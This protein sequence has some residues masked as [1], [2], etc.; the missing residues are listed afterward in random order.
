MGEWT[1]VESMLRGGASSEAAV[2]F[3]INYRTHF[4][5]N[6]EFFAKKA[7]QTAAKNEEALGAVLRRTFYSKKLVFVF[8]QK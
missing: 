8:L 3:L 4:T 7:Q 6:E 1:G 2:L 5:K